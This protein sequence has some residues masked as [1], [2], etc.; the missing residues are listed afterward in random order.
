MS[1]SK[2]LFKILALLLFL[3]SPLKVYGQDSVSIRKGESAPFS[4]TLLTD[5]S[6]A[7]LLVNAEL[8][9]EKVKIEYQIRLDKLNA[10]YK[11]SEELW[12]IQLESQ[13]SRYNI[14]VESQDRQLDY[15]LKANT[16]PTISREVAFIIGIASGVVLATASA[17]S[18]SLVAQAN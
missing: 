7:T 17:Y 9:E 5:K 13:Q 4:G 15:L 2:K 3:T 14:V 8:C 6:A 10:K 12:K 18:Y 1:I 11:L 16:K